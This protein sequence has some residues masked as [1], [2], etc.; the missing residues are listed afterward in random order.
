MYERI[1]EIIGDII[2]LGLFIYLD[3]IA[4][5]VIKT[6]GKLSKLTESSPIVKTIL[7]LGTIGFIV[8]I[9]LNLI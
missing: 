1:G 7:I 5:R 6:D 8:M 2:P 9:I 3:L 4:F